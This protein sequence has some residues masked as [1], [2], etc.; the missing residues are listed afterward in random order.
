MDTELVNGGYVLG[1]GGLPKTVAGRAELLQYARMNLQMHRGAWPY[2]RELGSGLWQLDRG[3]DHPEER[4]LAL[5][6]EA[7]LRLPGVRAKA[8]RLTEKGVAFLIA[9]PLG[10]EE[11]EVGEL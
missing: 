6:N 4:A 2:N 5:A 9:T 8:A 3:E 7:L 10:E 1:A 11:I